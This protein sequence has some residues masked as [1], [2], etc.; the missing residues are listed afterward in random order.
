VNEITAAEQ[1]GF[2]ILST[3]VFLPTV[4]I[5]VLG[6]IRSELALRRVALAGAVVVLALS[7]VLAATFRKGVT[8]FQFAEQVPWVQSMGLSYHLAVDGVSIL[9]VPLTALLVV[10]VMLASW[11][12]VRHQATAYLMAL[13]AF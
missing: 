6:F 7:L 11:T 5:V 2:P 13:L 4:I 9:F 10:I 3:L 1:V 8:D 12:S